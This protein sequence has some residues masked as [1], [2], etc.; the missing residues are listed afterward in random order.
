MNVL[1]KKYA[2]LTKICQIV[3]HFPLL[4]VDLKFVPVCLICCALL[5]S[6]ASDVFILQNIVNEDMI[7]T[8]G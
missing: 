6:V 3:V 5:T 7:F 8:I 1:K 2:L 4:C